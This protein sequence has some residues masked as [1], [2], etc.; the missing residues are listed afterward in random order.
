MNA[1]R[2]HDV[3]TNRHVIVDDG[4]VCADLNGDGRIAKSEE[5]GAEV[6]GLRHDALIRAARDIERVCDTRVPGVAGT[7]PSVVSGAT[8]SAA[9]WQE[10]QSA[11]GTPVVR[12]PLEQHLAFFDRRN[13]GRI[14]LADN[15]WGWRRLGF[16][17]FKSLVQAIGSAVVFGSRHGGTIVIAEINST[18]PSRPTGIYDRDGGIDEMRWARFRGAFEQHAKDEVLAQQQARAVLEQQASLGRVPRRQFE[19]L[20]AVC[21][22][23]N[24]SKTITIQEIR[25]LYDGSLLYR[26]A[27]MTDDSG[28]RHR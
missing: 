22:K 9:E 24:R 12:S 18:R 21:E 26:A 19:S 5:V 25:W 1:I 20:F 13:S 28:R 15:Y 10:F 27:S 23:M 17:V 11:R 2:L 4:R 14:S 3:I 7:D 6:L 8:L 16:G